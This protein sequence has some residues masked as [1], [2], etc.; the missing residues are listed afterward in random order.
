ML[1]VYM[2]TIHITTCCER[3]YNIL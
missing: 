1:P 3:K 2:K